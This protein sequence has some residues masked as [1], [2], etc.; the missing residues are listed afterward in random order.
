MSPL[1]F[2]ALLKYWRSRTGL[3]QLDL[4]MAAG[5]SARH[6]SFLET[7]RAQPGEVM[8][9][10]L[11]AALQVPL[12]HQNEALQAAGFAARF[13]TPELDAI[14]PAIHAALDRMLAQQEPYP[15]TLL[16][17]DYRILRSNRAAGKI[18][19]GFVLEPERLLSEAL[20]MF[21]LLFDPE[22]ARPFIVDWPHLA[23]RM[24]A[25]LHREVLQDPG[26]EAL[27]DRL[28]RALRYPGVRDEWRRP[29]FAMPIDSSLNFRLSRDDVRIGFLT[30][31]TMFSAP[32]LVTLEELRIESYFPLDDATRMYCEQRASD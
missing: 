5:I 10:K 13:E 19:E 6:L 27:A 16:S 30:T 23:A 32:G 11:M 7:G 4:A 22:L 8:V 21:G 26:N 9:L 24:L 29:D 15:L 12:R 14:P 25:R 31:L 3:S 28:T 18:F 17:P 2:A 1:V 20:D